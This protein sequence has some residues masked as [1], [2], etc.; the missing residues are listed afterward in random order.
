MIAADDD[1]EMS[2]RMVEAFKKTPRGKEF[3]VILLWS[4]AATP[5]DTDA[6][7]FAH[8]DAILSTEN[9]DANEARA[10]VRALLEA[11]PGRT[12]PRF[13]R[14]GHLELDRDTNSARI[15][16]SVATDIPEKHFSLL[17]FL[18]KRALESK[19]LCPRD[20]ILSRLW[21][22]KV[23][24]REVDVTISRLKSR[25]PFLAPFVES[26]PRKGYRLVSPT[27]TQQNP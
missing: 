2:G 13:L 24:D 25:L 14:F 15:G 18:A 7:V 19:D 22:N 8:A 17:W 6:L 4:K 9:L 11:P 23:R 27:L 10:S 21:K 26:V 5:D 20:V 12:G 1:L 16:A 3:P